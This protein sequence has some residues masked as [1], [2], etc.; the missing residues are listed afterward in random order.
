MTEM[1]KMNEYFEKH[2]KA[3]KNSGDCS[4]LLLLLVTTNQR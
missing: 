1:N 2:E 3:L 4:H